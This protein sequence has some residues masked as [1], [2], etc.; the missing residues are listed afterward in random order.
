MQIK[1][2]KRS[3]KSFTKFMLTE[4]KKI[5]KQHYGEELDYSYWHTQH[6]YFKAQQGKKTV[7]GLI[8]EFMAGV[9]YVSEL[10]VD[11]NL[12]G[13]GIGESLLKKAE[14]WAKKHRGHEVHLVTGKDWQANKFYLKMGYKKIADLLRHYS[15]ADFVVL[16]KFL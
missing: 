4:W 14:D 10:I 2:L 13:Q 11:T 8:G 1:Q 7:G 15:Q 6:I 12:R 9:L 16:T 3:T 5:H